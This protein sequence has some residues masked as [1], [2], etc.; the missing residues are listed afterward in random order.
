MN[1]AF[2]LESVDNTELLGPPYD[3]S[4]TSTFTIRGGGLGDRID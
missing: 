2:D 1:V 4:M 3:T